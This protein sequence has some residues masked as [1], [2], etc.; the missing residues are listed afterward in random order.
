MPSALTAVL[1]LYRMQLHES[2]CYQTLVQSL[3]R[4][5]HV[6]QVT[7]FVYDNSPDTGAA[8]ASDA[9]DS[10]PGTLHYQHDPANGG[11]AAAY[12]AGLVEARRN[13]SAWL[14][15]LDQDTNL[16][17]GYVAE[18]LQAAA[19]VPGSVSAIIPRLTQDGLTHSP[20][21]RPRLSHRS[22]A[23]DV[24][25]LLPVQV[26]AFNSGAALRVAAL[27]SFP[28]RYWLDFLDHAVFHT[29]QKAGGR[30]WLLAAT[31]EHHLSTEQLGVDA[32]VS[33]YRNVL[34]AER[35]FYCDYGSTPD[36]LLYHL[37][38]SKQAVG[39]LLHVPD[40]QFALLSLRAALGLLPAT[41]PR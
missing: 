35:D 32:T 3:Q 1:V 24:T 28:T 11:V 16:T 9:A 29:L 15:L 23:H 33:R 27:D 18:L 14:L 19:T 6:N 37:R 25:G 34:M 31:L 4:T 26:T 39:L 17:P 41:P 13:G 2:R 5:G 7:L 40:K 36:R 22:L 21:L 10:F 20:Q 8:P 38:R 30:V 12:N